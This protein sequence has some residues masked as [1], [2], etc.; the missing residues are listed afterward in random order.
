[1]RY[2]VVIV[3]SYCVGQFVVFRCLTRR[4]SSDKMS[5]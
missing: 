5:I 3:S 1:V 4:L 2:I